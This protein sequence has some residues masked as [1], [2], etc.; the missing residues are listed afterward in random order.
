M[1]SNNSIPTELPAAGTRQRAS[2]TAWML[3]AFLWPVVMLNYLDRQ[4]VSTI[5]ASIRADIPSIANDQEFGTLMATFMWVYAVLSPVGG[6]VADKVNRRWTVIG[7]LLAWSLVTYLTGRAR[8]Y[9]EM[10]VLRALMGISEAF[11]MPA[12]LSLVANFHPPTTRARAVGIHLSGT[13]F[14]MSLGGIGGYVGQISSWRLCFTGFGLVGILYAVVLMWILPDDH[15]SE[16]HEPNA[17]PISIGDTF[18]SLLSMPSYWILLAYFTLPAISGWVAK[19]WFPTYMA[20]AFHLKQGPAGMLATGFI[21]I[22]SLTGVI[23]GGLLADL[24]MRRSIRGHI[25]I[26]AIGSTLL[27]PALIGLGHPPNLAMACAFM[28]LFG[29]SWGFFDCN[30]MPILCQ[31]A[32]REH[33]ATGYGMM[34]MVSIAS[35]GGVTVILGWMR[36]HG[37][38]FSM[39]FNASAVVAVI[40]AIS[41]LFIRPR[42]LEQA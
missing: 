5:R 30:N 35:G 24:W 2:R 3:V 9:N 22:S 40:G 27:A 38:H 15:D 20:D 36:D 31:I 33:R 28:T 39:A 21:Q 8:T 7:S 16:F 4:M 25:W 12:A 17:P 6:Y 42:R 10:L 37:I 14:G 29:L 13:Y 11:Y 18:G 26:S 19:N 32:R 1:L 41:V 34:N 23:L